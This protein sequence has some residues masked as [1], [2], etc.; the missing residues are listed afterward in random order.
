MRP[1]DEE[2][3]LLTISDTE[4]SMNEAESGLAL[5]GI[6]EGH[7]PTWRR[8]DSIKSNMDVF[9]LAE[10]FV[11]RHAYL[12]FGDDIL[13]TTTPLHLCRTTT[14]EKVNGEVVKTRSEG[15]IYS[16]GAVILV[17]REDALVTMLFVDE[18]TI[19]IFNYPQPL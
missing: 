10:R 2:I 7:F 16:N 19:N 11:N 13:Y 1:T 17:H 6:V 5:M 18:S 4:A 15:L 9:D 3:S 12:D 14:N 8:Y